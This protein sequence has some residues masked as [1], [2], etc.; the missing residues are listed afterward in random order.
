M[1]TGRAADGA[2]LTPSPTKRRTLF[3]HFLDVHYFEE[4]IVRSIVR[5]VISEAKLAI[6]IAVILGSEILIPAAAYYENNETKRLLDEFEEAEYRDIFFLV[7]S[8]GS[9]E[10][11]VDEKLEQYPVGTSI[12]SSYRKK[13]LRQPFPWRTRRRSSTTDIRNGWIKLPNQSNIIEEILEGRAANNKDIE[14]EWIKLPDRLCKFAFTPENA[15]NLL[16][17]L[18]NN[19]VSRQ[20]VAHIIN[21]LYFTSHLRDFPAGLIQRLHWLSGGMLISSSRPD[22]DID[23]SSLVEGLR[24][25]GILQEI[26]QANVNSLR[27]VLY[28]ERFVRSF[29]ATQGY[30]APRTSIPSTGSSLITMNERGFALKQAYPADFIVAAAIQEL[31]AIREYLNELGYVRSEAPPIENRRVEIFEI[32]TSARGKFSFG[33]MVAIDKGKS[34]MKSLLEAIERNTSAAHVIM[35]GMMAGIKNKTRLLDVVVPRTVY[36]GTAIGTKAGKH[37][38]EP[39]AGSMDAKLHHWTA[40]MEQA[41]LKAARIRLISQKKTVTVAAKI[42]DISHGLAKSALAVDPENVVGLEMEASALIEQQTTQSLRNKAVGYLMVK[43]VADYAG[44]RPDHVEVMDLS[45]ISALK[46]HLADADPTNS[47]PLKSALQKEATRRALFVALETLQSV[48]KTR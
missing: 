21:E 36:D 20:R 27:A 30:F 39:E 44:D 9:V 7:G 6:R 16:P 47:V 29:T 2:I 32:E 40:S 18:Q 12:G 35:V 3:L 31:S 43:G 34:Q 11:F 5:S 17:S 42:D 38:G 22:L 13:K 33:L 23:F 46:D 25:S 26:Q 4:R 15:C 45:S 8:G 24:E 37:V 28:D 19:I 1:P 41:S 10:Q 14:D 48:T